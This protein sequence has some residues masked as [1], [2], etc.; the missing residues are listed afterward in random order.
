MFIK[1]DPGPCPIDDMPHTTCVA[2]GTSG[3]VIVAGRIDT[4]QTIIVPTPS[5]PPT[6]PA[7]IAEATSTPPTTFSTKDYRGRGKREPPPSTPGA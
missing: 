3:G 1:A 7:P 2:P 6:A 5:T 4:P